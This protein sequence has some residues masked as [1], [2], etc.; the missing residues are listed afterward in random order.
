MKKVAEKSMK[1]IILLTLSV[2]SFFV[3]SL[4][5]FALETKELL[6]TA[7][8]SFEKGAYQEAVR[9]YTEVLSSG[10]INGHLYYNL[11]NAYYRLGEI[12]QA[13]SAY[14]RAL[15]L[16]P[17][18]PDVKANLALA[19]KQVIDKLSGEE[20]EDISV[21]LVNYILFLNSYLSKE[22]LTCLFLSFYSIS[23]LLLGMSRYF[24]KQL[25]QT[26]SVVGFIISIF[27]SLPAFFSTQRVDGRW[28][29]SPFSFGRKENIVV[30]TTKEAHAYAS[31]A[32]KTQVVFVLHDGA[33]VQLGEVRDGW[34]E[35]HLPNGRK[36]WLKRDLI[37]I[38]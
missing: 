31:N 24:R 22:K 5:C 21:T 12:G 37:S 7:D 26:I 6:V 1:K 11:G 38:I 15:L 2:C 36:G 3:F 25:L 23:F 14:R 13:I 10:V 17:K 18:D 32:E 27:L 20:K 33:E 30:V 8:T 28:A 29:F 16:L 9:Y 35:A 4:N 19:R 34:V